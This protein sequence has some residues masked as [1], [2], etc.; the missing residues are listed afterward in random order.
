MNSEVKQSDLLLSFVKM[1]NLYIEAD[2]DN[3]KE[4]RI[5]PRDEFYNGSQVDWTKKLDYSQSVEIV[6]MGEL[7]ANPY[8]FQYKEGKD[9]AN[10][11]YQ[12]SYQTTYGS[13]TYQVEN[14]FVKEEKKIEVVFSPTQIRSYNNQKNFVLSYVPNSQDGDLRVM[15][16]SGLVSGV[17][18]MLYAQYA[19]VGVNRSN[20]FSIPI[21]THLDDIANP[22]FDINFG[23]PREI[24]LGAGYKYTNANLV[25]TYYYRFLTEIT[26]KNSKILR[27][28]FRITTKDYLNL[29]FSDAYFFE[30][31][32]WRLNKIEDYDPNGDS[33]YLC[34]FLLAQF[35][36]PATITQKTIGAGTGQGQQGETYGDIYPGGS[37]PFKPGIKGVSVGTSNGGSGVFV[38]DG[39]VQSSNNDNSSAFASV[40]TSFLEGA[41]NSIAVV[42]DDFAVTKPD[43]M[44]V[45]N[46][47]MYPNFL[48]GGSVKTI[49]TNYTATKDDW[50]IIANTSAGSLTITLPDPTSLSGK[51]WVIKKPLSGHSVTINTAT[52]AQ[53]DGSDSHTQ[54]TH[55]SYDVI[56]T[57]GVQ[58]YIIAEGH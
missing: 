2:R 11:L 55:H 36:Q 34:E 32:Y 23:M 35:I 16:Y 40:N 17:N 41:D 43:T 9:D 6:P 24:G 54:T 49:T 30:G 56:T 58:F 51:T 25:N 15:Y 19:G 33:V 8:K 22:T 3:P 21:T 53:I 39:I 42:C 5:V 7:E 13:R 50:L 14:Q 10:V 29:S 27:A 52:S 18:W 4:L 28:Y 44:Y 31:Q 12:E 48:S 20:R 1:F 57:D 38:G 37:I 47:E 46:Y 45:G 26:S